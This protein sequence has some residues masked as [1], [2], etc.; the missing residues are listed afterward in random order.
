MSTPGMPPCPPCRFCPAGRWRLLIV[1]AWGWDDDGRRPVGAT[2]SH[3]LEAGRSFGGGRRQVGNRARASG[4]K[5]R[6]S[7]EGEACEGGVELRIPCATRHWATVLKMKSDGRRRRWGAGRSE[8]RANRA[9]CRQKGTTRNKQKRGRARSGE[10][11]KGRPLESKSKKRRT[12][13]KLRQAGCL[14]LDE[15]RKY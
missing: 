11:T 2:P 15:G 9:R 6:R 14:T 1:P 3:G 4:L 10:K 13:S 7:R 8:G 12:G 5:P